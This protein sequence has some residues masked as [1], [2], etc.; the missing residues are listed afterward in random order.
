[1]KYRV[2]CLRT[3][4]NIRPHGFC[5]TAPWGESEGEGDGHSALRHCPQ[6]MSTVRAMLVK[7]EGE[8]GQLSAK[9]QTHNVLRKNTGPCYKLVQ[10]EHITPMQWSRCFS[11]ARLSSF[12]RCAVHTT[13]VDTSLPTS[14]SP[15]R[16][17]PLQAQSEAG[18]IHLLIS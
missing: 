1:M 17:E 7:R 10:S 9:N 11:T 8:I 4:G 18:I 2:W 15:S 16:A 14:C 5:V 12:L 3:R 13:R 6:Q